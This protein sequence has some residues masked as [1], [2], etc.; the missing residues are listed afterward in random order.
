M[1]Q[2][3]GRIVHTPAGIRNISVRLPSGI[4]PVTYHTMNECPTTGL[5]YDACDTNKTINKNV[6]SVSVNK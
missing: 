4:G 2:P 3:T 5:F 1:H 6:F